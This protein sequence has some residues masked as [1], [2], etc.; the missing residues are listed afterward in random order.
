MY[1][2]IDGTWHVKDRDYVGENGNFQYVETACGITEVW[3]GIQIDALPGGNEVV[4]AD[5]GSAPASAPEPKAEAKA[6]ASEPVGPP[7]P[8][9]AARKATTRRKK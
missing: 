4:H 2:N 9:P 5:C 1:V 8:R 6:K 7:R 3:N